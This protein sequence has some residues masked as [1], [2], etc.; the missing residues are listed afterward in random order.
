MKVADLCQRMGSA[1]SVL[2]MEWVAIVTPHHLELDWLTVGQYFAIS[3]DV[4]CVSVSSAKLQNPGRLF[5]SKADPYLAL[6]IDGQ[7]PRKTEIVRKS[8]SPTWNE[9]FTV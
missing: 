5:S 7:P 1:D 2:S 3:S 6:S 8:N 9:H 4:L